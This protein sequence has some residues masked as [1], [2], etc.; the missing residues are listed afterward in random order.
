MNAELKGYRF[1]VLV[2]LGLLTILLAL[3]VSK[4]FSDL[5]DLS[6][7]KG[8]TQTRWHSSQ[9][10]TQIADLDSILTENIANVDLQR[11]AIR[12]KINIVLSKLF[13]LKNDPYLLNFWE[14]PGLGASGLMPLF[15]FETRAI[16]IAD[17]PAQITTSDLLDLRDIL[18]KARPVA[19][20]IS[21]RG[22]ELA[23]VQSTKR[24]TKFA[25]QL[26]WTGGFAIGFLIM[27]ASLLLLMDRMLLSAIR[28]AAALTA[29]SKQLA[30]TVAG[31]LDAI[32]IA[33]SFSKII[34]YN[35]SAEGVFGWTRKEIIGRTMEDIFLPE[36]LRDTYKNAM[37]QPLLQ[38]RSEAI[39]PTRFELSGRRKNGEEFPVELNMTFVKRN[40]DAIFMAYIRDV[41]D[42]K[43][44]EKALIEAR[45]RA[46]SA[47]KAKSQFLAVMSHEMR[48]PLAGIIGIMDL[49][50]TTKLSQ[51]Q[52]RYI[53]IATSSSTVLLDHI[54]EALNITR[55]D[56][57]KLELSSQEFNLPDLAET[58][59]EVL[60]PLSNQKNLDL[61]LQLAN[62]IKSNF[63]GDS[64]RIRQ[65]LTNLLGN[66][67]KFTD[68]GNINFSIT[69]SD[70]P[71]T[72]FVHF[73]ISDTGLGI[74]PENHQKIFE[75]F[76]AITQGDQSQVRGDGL[77]LHI[78]R[79]IARLMGGDVMVKSDIGKGAEFTLSL[80][81]EKVRKIDG[82]VAEPASFPHKENQNL[83][84]LVVEDNN[85]NREV[86]GDMLK[87]LGHSVSRATNGV[88][89]LDCAN[90]QS[91]DIIFMDINMPVM[92]GIEATHRIRADSKLN[93]KAC[94]FGLTAHG[95]DEFG[96]EAQQAGMDNFFTK[97][98]RLEALRKIISDIV[99]NDQ[100]AVIDEFS[101]V[102][103]ELFETLGRE[104]VLRIGEKFF[105][106]LDV[107]IQQ[108]I[109]GVFAEDHVALVE[110]THKMKGAAVLLGQ[111][112]LE[113]PLDQLECHTLEGDVTDLTNSIQSLRN[114]AQQSKAAF[115][116]FTP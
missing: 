88:E 69:G 66:A 54:N 8:N 27:L 107:F 50:K 25:R 58:L 51:K 86:L 26:T 47:D 81:L 87:G 46:E 43:I 32:V 109:D 76:V 9:F 108:S 4:L 56:V 106:E 62:N 39:Y 67:I 75:E 85:V 17:K 35:A 28:R 18:R 41:S 82:K 64:H 10:E 68:Q 101:P 45:D 2:G 14:N 84:I 73:I 1:V 63:M 74:A 105:E 53:Q 94:I 7:S 13:V 80:P 20:K 113:T 99:S 70:G 110:A 21:L 29:S 93:S 16:A 96:E 34:E 103:T 44:T 98:I 55:I 19:R 6:V 71:E 57:G 60:E 5:Q 104:K 48:T 83:S 52:D 30:A 72:S 42:R 78:S 37:N 22:A 31:S 89:A 59:V 114:I 38:D 40:D 65:I 33:D 112:V 97:P 115:F 92:D 116:D 102:L 61:R 79:K 3:M 91:F 95:S 24:R 100:F 23:G 12:Q 11:D 49:L 90:I 111:N 77:G 36:G 15:Q